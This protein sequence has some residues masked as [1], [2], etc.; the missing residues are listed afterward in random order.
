MTWSKFSDDHLEREDLANGGPLVLAM[1]EACTIY[2][3]KK[4]TDGRVP[5]SIART[6]TDFTNSGIR[7]VRDGVRVELWGLEAADAVIDLAIE[8]GVFSALAGG[9]IQVNQIGLHLPPAAVVDE[10][11]EAIS[12]MRREVGRRG[13]QQSVLSRAA[14]KAEAIASA[15]LKQRLANAEANQANGNQTPSKGEANWK[16]MPEANQ[17]N[18]KQLLEIGKQNSSK[19]EAPGSRERDQKHTTCGEG[20]G[21]SDASPPPPPLERASKGPSGPVSVRAATAPGDGP[22][23]AAKAVWGTF[24]EA[25]QKGYRTTY[26]GVAGGEGRKAQEMA[27]AAHDAARSEAAARAAAGVPAVVSERELLL[28]ALRYWAA[29]YVADAD[30]FLLREKHPLRLL[31]QAIPRLGFPPAWILERQRAHVGGGG[32]AGSGAR[33]ASERAPRQAM[34]AEHDWDAPEFVGAREESA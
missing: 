21:S 32:A 10:R 5:R 17:A 8:L 34:R 13:G 16:Q 29:A 14:S 23:D 6:L 11:R 12:A 30:P 4:N 28:E 2:S 19:K 7:I 25:Y 1:H 18:G 24:R 26:A 33:R 22:H 15:E 20:S 31:P 3:G 27:K 9:A